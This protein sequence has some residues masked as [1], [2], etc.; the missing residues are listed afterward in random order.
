[1][2]TSPLRIF[3]E[4][5]LVDVQQEEYPVKPYFRSFFTQMTCMSV[6]EFS[7]AVLDNSSADA[8]GPLCRRVIREA[9]EELRDGFALNYILE[10]VI[11]RKVI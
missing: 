7:W 9:S 4:L 11:G 8:S 2:G 3:S 6:E 5:G 1:M 10:A